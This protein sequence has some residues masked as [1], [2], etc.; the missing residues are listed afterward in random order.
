MFKTF[1]I[2]GRYGDLNKSFIAQKL[3]TGLELGGMVFDSEKPELIIC[4]GGDGSLLKTLNAYQYEGKYLLINGGT[5]GFLSDFQ[6]NEVDKIIHSILNVEPSEEEHIPLV[7][8]DL[9]SKQKVYYAANEISLFSPVRAVNY[10]MYLNDEKLSEFQS[11]GLLISSSLGSTAY[12][13][14]CGGPILMTGDDSFIINIVLPLQNRV[15]QTNFKTIVVPASTK[16]HINVEQNCRIY[17]VACDG[18]EASGLFSHDLYFYQSRKKKFY[19]LHY[20]QK[21]KVTSIGHSFGKL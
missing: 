13:L 7:V 19:I 10:T 20:R 1:T 17:K 14:S 3:K 15:T 11:S 18:M 16:V 2:E 9:K 21:S 6:M 8:E 4:I 12:N 5:L